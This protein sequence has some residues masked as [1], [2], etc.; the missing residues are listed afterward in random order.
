MTGQWMREG[1]GLRWWFDAGS[2][3]LDFA[4]T[5]GF[6]DR[7]AM[8]ETPET[9]GD[10]LRERYPEVDAEVTEREL[11]DAR[12]LRASLARL[13]AASAKGSAA[14]EDVDVVNLFGATADIPP[15]LAGGS[16]QAGRTRARVGQ[17][18]SAIAR[19]AIAVFGPANAER[20]RECAADD[21][22]LIFYDESRSN[23]RQWC[24]MQRC[25]NRA[26]VRTFRERSRF[27]S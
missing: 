13:A 27:A 24:S 15:S 1:S 8:V 26:K 2:V 10:W 11:Q 25:G 18:L 4:H 17:A 22:H 12:A 3:A 14:A 21:C 16:R 7:R 20:I 23:N 5:G 19:D 6:D 9:L